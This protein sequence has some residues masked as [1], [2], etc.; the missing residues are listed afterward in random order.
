M[1]KIDRKLFEATRNN[2]QECFDE[3][4]SAGGSEEYIFGASNYEKSLVKQ[5]FELAQDLVK[6]FGEVSD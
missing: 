3:L 2:L 5:V 6:E 1:Q 4:E